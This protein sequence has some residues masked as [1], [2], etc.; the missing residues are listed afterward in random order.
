MIPGWEIA[1]RRVSDDVRVVGLLTTGAGG[2]AE[3]AVVPDELTVPI[4][5]GVEDAASC[6]AR[7]CR[8]GNGGGDRGRW[9]SP[10]PRDPDRAAGWCRARHRRNLDR[11]EALSH[12]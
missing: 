2:Y 5:D 1:G 3:Y 10:K 4:P 11:G 7:G 8:T 9:R 6:Q 12:A